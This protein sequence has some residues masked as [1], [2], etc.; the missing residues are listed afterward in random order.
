[1]NTTSARRETGRTARRTD[2]AAVLAAGM[3]AL[4]ACSGGSSSTPS[5][6]SPDSATSTPS[7]GSSDSGMSMPMITIK[8]FTFNGPSSVKPGASVMVT[9]QDT[10]AHTLTADNAGGFSVK[11]DPGKSIAFTAPN[12]P[13]S[14]P[15]HCDFHSN[16]Q[17]TLNVS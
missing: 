6:S 5:Q 15:Y 3:I 10:E 1:M 9:N 12:K 16:M 14:Y 8:D 4:S 2:L 17:G 7:P 13:G 11:V